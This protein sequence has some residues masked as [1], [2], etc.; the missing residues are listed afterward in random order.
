MAAGQDLNQTKPKMNFHAKTS[1]DA[2]STT[3]SSTIEFSAT[4]IRW[5]HGQICISLH[6]SGLLFSSQNKLASS[7]SSGCVSNENGGN[8]NVMLFIAAT[9]TTSAMTPVGGYLKLRF[10]D[11][12]LDTRVICM[13]QR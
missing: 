1:P 6:R 4:L 13:L 10:V 12:V 9:A 7:M 2:S 3:T 8:V 11:T 5:T